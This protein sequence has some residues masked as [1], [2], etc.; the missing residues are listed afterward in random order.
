MRRL[1]PEEAGAA[2]AGLQPISGRARGRVQFNL[3]G[4]SWGALVEIRESDSSIGM[5]GIPGPVRIASGSVNITPDVVKIDRA[6]VSMLDARATASATIG[7]GARPRIEGSVSGGSVG[8][9]ALAWVWKSAGLPPNM[10]LKTP[11]RVEVQ[12]AA[13]SPKQPLDLTA[14]AAFDAGPSVAVDLSWTPESLD[15]RRA[16]LKDERSDAAIA[17]RIKGRLLEGRFSGSMSGASIQSMLKASQIRSGS[18]SGDLRFTVDLD[19]PRRTSAEGNLK[20]EGLDL[21]AL[22]DR[23]V[24]IERID[25]AAAKSSL[26]IREATVNWAEQTIRLRGD[27]RYGARGPVIDAQLE[28][29]GV[30]VDA[31]LRR[32]GENQ[33]PAAE[34][35]AKGPAEEYVW[36]QWPLPVTG[37]IAL[38]TDF[39]QYGKRKAAPVAAVLVLEE[40]RA[41]LELQQVKLCG[42]SLPLTVE[43]TSTGLAIA[44][45]I[46]AQKQQLEQTARCLTEEGVQISGNFDLSA[47]LRTQ[48][49]LR[50]LLPNLEGNVSAEL[51]DGRVMKF[52]L[53]GNIL[54][55]KGVSDLLKDGAPKADDAGFSYRSLSAKGRFARGRFIIDESAFDSSA[56]GLAATGWIS[57]VDYDSKLSVLVAPEWIALRARC[58][59][60]GISWAGL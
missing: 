41:T 17:L 44:G 59:S 27:V 16:G 46:T 20:A 2:L 31:L 26:R 8:E 53:L 38:R 9:S 33:A 21:T 14:T 45:R 6:D 25:L 36:T 47:D 28:S 55:L 19:R 12:K 30:L 58:R 56:F 60:S 40:Q 34:K 39:I 29:P 32:S 5:E 42:I 51:R 15:I 50:Q 1:L 22:L 35:K 18:A 52:A 24:K 57:L 7:Y 11:V 23:P 13:W 49:R 43:A 4:S 37:R 3:E 48:G 54:S 10:I